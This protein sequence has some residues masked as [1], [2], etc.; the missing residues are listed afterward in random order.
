M[1]IIGSKKFESIEKAWQAASGP[2]TPAAWAELL[3]SL[4]VAPEDVC[5]STYIYVSSGREIVACNKRSHQSDPADEERKIGYLSAYTMN[6]NGIKTAMGGEPINAPGTRP[7]TSLYLGDERRAW[8]KDHGGIQ[9]TIH[10]MI[11]RAMKRNP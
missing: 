5:R 10:T 11:D 1:N 8:L 3:K 2:N 4:S 9:P 6:F 7:D